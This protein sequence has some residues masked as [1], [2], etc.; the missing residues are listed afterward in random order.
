MISAGTER[1][2]KNCRKGAL[3]YTCNSG[4]C[5]KKDFPYGRQTDPLKPSPKLLEEGH[6]RKDGMLGM[7]AGFA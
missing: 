2:W 5:W 3:D 7:A 6:T 4:F 1:D